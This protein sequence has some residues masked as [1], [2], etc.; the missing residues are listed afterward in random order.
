MVV[1]Y[2]WKQILTSLA[3]RV[4]TPIM[5]LHIGFIQNAAESDGVMTKP[6]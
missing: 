5:I 3:Q 2:T 4:D 1:D 6:T